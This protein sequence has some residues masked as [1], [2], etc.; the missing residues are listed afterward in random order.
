MAW[1]L[2]SV[3]CS[4]A[5]LTN[6]KYGNIFWNETTQRLVKDTKIASLER[7]IHELEDELSSARSAGTMTTAEREEEMKQLDAYK[8]HN[9]FM[10]TKV[11][12]VNWKLFTER[13]K[14]SGHLCVIQKIDIFLSSRFIL[15]SISRNKVT[16]PGLCS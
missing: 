10:K 11:E 12:I 15:G 4:T 2:E 14:N 1:I 8:T 6:A 16:V 7:I 5:S 9:N 13:C 3:E